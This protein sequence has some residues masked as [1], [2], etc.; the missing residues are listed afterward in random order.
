MWPALVWNTVLWK[1]IHKTFPQFDWVQTKTSMNVSGILCD[2]YKLM[3][4]GNCD[5]GDEYLVSKY[6][7]N[8]CL[9]QCGLHLSWYP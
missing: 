4:A 3:H 2:E 5:I 1:Y 8:W 9:K 7:T 6:C